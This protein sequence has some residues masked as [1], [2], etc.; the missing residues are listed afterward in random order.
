MRIIAGTHRGR[1]LTPV[2]KGDAGAHLRPTTDRIR[3]SI[4]NILSGG[5]IG[6]DIEDAQ[7]ADIF[8]G[9]GAMGLE[10][11][12][13][14]AAHVTFVDNGR[15][16]LSLV[17]KNIALLNEAPRTKINKSDARRLPTLTPPADLIFLDPPYGTGLGA[18][19][20]ERLMKTDSIAQGA[21]IV[22]EDNIA[23]PT[24]GGIETL[25]TRSFGTTTV[26]F[27]QKL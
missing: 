12:S 10:A 19:A 15:A 23:A 20:L 21:I 6:A 16:A 26:T 22:F 27:F 1:A 8:C 11:L 3:E 18:L 13:R 17:Q 14:G 2:G 24:F 5:R 7:V 4:F 9:T 25:D